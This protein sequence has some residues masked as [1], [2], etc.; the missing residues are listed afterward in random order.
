[1]QK[2]PGRLLLVMAQA[3]CLLLLL[4]GCLLSVDI[5][6]PG[7][8]IP[9]AYEGASRHA[10]AAEAALPKLDWWRSFHSRELTQ[11]IEDVRATKKQRIIDRAKELLSSIIEAS[12]MSHI[13]GASDRLMVNLLGR[14]A[15]RDILTN[16]GIRQK[17]RPR[18]LAGGSG[19]LTW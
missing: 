5:P 16:T 18:S 4:G 12:K 6:K 13:R 7:L 2:G 15:E 10:A 1:M 14:Q 3:S 17:N 19:S 8:D 11:I 9:A